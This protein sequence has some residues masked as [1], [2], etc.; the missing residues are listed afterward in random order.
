MKLRR[1][2]RVHGLITVAGV[3]GATFVQLA[4]ARCTRAGPA[5]SVSTTLRVGVGALPQTSQQVGVRQIISG[6]SAEGLVKPQEDGRLR[7]NLAKGWSVTSDEL[8]TIV[9]LRQDATFHDGTPV[10]AELVAK[11]L[12]KDLP[13]FM[14]AAFD[15]V[16][17][18]EA[19]DE[20]HVRLEVRRPTQFLLEALDTP[21]QLR[22]QQTAGTG[23]YVPDPTTSELKANPRYYFGQPAIQRITFA[24]YPSVRTA[25]AE[26]L[27]GNVDMLYEV[28]ADALD[29]L[30]AATNVAVFSFPRHYQLM[31]IFGPRAAAFQSSDVRRELNA[32]ID[33][34]AI[35]RQALNGHGLPSTGPVPPSHWAL[36]TSAP[37]LEM[38][39]MLANRLVARHLQ[40]TC[41]VPADSVYERVALA[42]K[43]QL[44]AASVDMR[45]VEATQ[46]EIVEAVK[47]NAYDAV[48]IDP[49]S[50]PTVFRTYRLFSSKVQFSPKPK[51]SAAIDMALDQIRSAISNSAYSDGVTKF[52]QAIV[53]DPPVLFLAWEQ[54]ARAVSRRFN[55]AVP[56]DGGDILNTLRLWRP[57]GA[58]QVAQTH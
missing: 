38:N 10:S 14:G 6:Q 1:Y 5:P 46:D 13:T 50:G 7:P 45:V 33:R 56:E 54:R 57:A 48:L 34:K 53:D 42:V 28:N 39:S 35:V 51:T 21:I 23:P 49:V 15:D 16:A 11:S 25:W 4:T 40:F 37:K 26:L 24:Q 58:Q 27:R 36:Q 31:I 32:A 30:Q 43:Q 29:S 9:E 19:L 3:L 52:Q 22:G 18:I 8:S 20:S 55:V 41:L 47:A 2:S 12:R 44:S 17:K